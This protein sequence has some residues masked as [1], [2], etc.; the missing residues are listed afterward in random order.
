MT[1]ALWLRRRG[2]AGG[3]RLVRGGKDLLLDVVNGSPVQRRHSG[4]VE[5]YSAGD[6]AETFPVKLAIPGQAL[7]ADCAPVLSA[8]HPGQLQRAAR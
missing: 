4:K 2:I 5:R 6:S 1:P 3:G 8:A 7:S